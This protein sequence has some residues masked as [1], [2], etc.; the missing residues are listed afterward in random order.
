MGFTP[1]SPNP[2]E[3]R[4][5]ERSLRDGGPMTGGNCPT[6]TR[7]HMLPE[8]SRLLLFL[9]LLPRPAP[10]YPKAGETLSSL[11]ASRDPMHGLGTARGSA[12]NHDRPSERVAVPAL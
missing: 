11:R 6:S 8:Q 9:H 3:G 5:Q 12:L 10:V 7:V 1:Q 2:Q 4:G